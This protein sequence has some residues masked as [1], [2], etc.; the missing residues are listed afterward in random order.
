VDLGLEVIL[1]EGGP[2]PAFWPKHVAIEQTAFPIAELPQ[3]LEMFG[4]IADYQ[5]RGAAWR[6]PGPRQTSSNA[7]CA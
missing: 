2:G 3:R 4:W 5:R 1:S 6:R 7:S